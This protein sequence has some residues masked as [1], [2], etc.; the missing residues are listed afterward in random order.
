MG[1]LKTM[2][3]NIDKVFEQAK[4]SMDSNLYLRLGNFLEDL[5]FDLRE[6]LQENTKSDIQNILR[7]LE[8]GQNPDAKD[9][10]LLRLWIV[11]E[12]QSYIETENSFNDWVNDLGRVIAEIKKVPEG[13]L[14]LQKIMQ[15]TGLANDGRRSAADIMNYLEKKERIRSFEESIQDLKDNEKRVHLIGILKYKMISP[16]N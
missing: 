8:N 6:R 10:D 1:D 2:R 3:D 12:A 11:S 14:D 7:K 4:S 5:K 16:D 9:V 15:L 13:S